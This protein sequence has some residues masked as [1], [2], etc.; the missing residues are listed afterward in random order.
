MTNPSSS[1]ARPSPL[2]ANAGAAVGSP[3]APA[4]PVI[5]N[6]PLDTLRAHSLTTALKEEIERLILGGE[7]KAGERLNESVLAARYKTSRGPIREALQALKQQR[8]V[9]FEKNRGAF[10]REVSLQEAEELYDIR[11]ALDEMVGRRLAE[12]IDQADLARLT[13]LTET[14]EAAAQ[15]EDIARYYPANLAF[16]D[17]LL[18]A[19]GNR[20]LMAIYRELI[21]ELHL[22]RR[23]GLSTA[24]ALHESNHEHRDL[25]QAITAGD[26]D[27]AALA[28][29]KHIECARSRLRSA[30][31]REAA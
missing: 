8:L 30:F 4:A 23:R 5:G 7:L 21:N 22:L 19:T 9:T 10:V 25:L 27:A 16:H 15:A 6:A 11:S 13:E 24:G 1:S 14:M 18:A 12:R 26:A 2:A 20:R 29:R 17:L 31:E 28:M 3:A